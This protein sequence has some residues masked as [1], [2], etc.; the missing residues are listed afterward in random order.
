MK[1]T[2]LARSL[3]LLALPLLAL[4]G[5]GGGGG[6]HGNGAA[7]VTGPNYVFSCSTPVNLTG[8]LL[9]GIPVP[10]G[11]VIVKD[12]NGYTAAT[13]TDDNGLFAVNI[14]CLQAPLVLE[15]TG[16]VAGRQVVEHGFMPTVTGSAPVANITPIT[17]AVLALVAGQDPTVYFAAQ[18]FSA[19]APVTLSALNASLV[20]VFRPVLTTFGLQVVD[21]Q[22]ASWPNFFSDPIDPRGRSGFEAALEL[23]HVVVMPASTS[24]GQPNG[25]IVEVSSRIDPTHL[26]MLTFHNGSLVSSAPAL[27]MQQSDIDSFVHI[28]TTGFGGI[29]D[30]LAI[31]NNELQNYLLL[32]PVHN[33]FDPAYTN[34]GFQTTLQIRNPRYTGAVI[35]RCVTKGQSPYLYD[36]PSGTFSAAKPSPVNVC[37]VRL[38]YGWNSASV[39][40][41]VM[42]RSSY[43]YETLRQLDNGRWD[44]YG[45]Q[46]HFEV[47]AG[48]R[49]FRAQYARSATV[50]GSSG[51]TLPANPPIQVQFAVGVNSSVLDSP[52]NQVLATGANIYTVD[53]QGNQ[54][55]LFTGSPMLTSADMPFTGSRLVTMAR[56]LTRDQ[57]Q[58]LNA[59]SG[60][61]LIEVILNNGVKDGFERFLNVVPDPGVVASAGVTAVPNLSL[62]SLSFPTLLN[63]SLSNFMTWD[64][65]NPLVLASTP[66]SGPVSSAVPDA[67]PVGDVT[68][69]LVY[70][71]TK[72]DKTTVNVPLIT[73]GQLLQAGFSVTVDQTQLANFPS[74]S[75]SVLLSREL[76]LGTRDE[77]ET[78]L[79]SAYCASQDLV[80]YCK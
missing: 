47:D 63:D 36:K 77:D 4:V 1:K 53:S 15:G 25:E 12:A 70:Q 76:L 29:D 49:Y 14:G 56:T 32:D 17:N 3:V 8:H 28:D 38:G 51:M 45:N 67:V 35:E 22:P 9:A 13:T 71:Q 58:Q 73:Q 60:H 33:D 10:Q 21:S 27:A 41:S 72:A 64:I 2:M 39:G 54:K 42:S 46:E 52:G 18:D 40:S 57:Q 44:L 7:L 50:S 79:V 78:L 23:L 55:P 62:A 59:V 19:L 26:V 20:T 5:C 6:G 30:L 66:L 11:N 31:I 48:L 61:V 24:L 69:A 80:T 74:V 43:Y 68:A 75:N 16:V 34:S 37:Q 65:V